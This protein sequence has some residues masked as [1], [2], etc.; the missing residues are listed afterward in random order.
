[1]RQRGFTLLEVLIAA[2]ILAIVTS[3][4]YA[5][6][7]N[8]TNSTDVVRTAMKELRARQFL[9]RVFLQNFTTIVTDPYLEDERF[10]F[11]AE[12]SEGGGGP[13]DKVFFCSTAPLL[14]GASFPGDI[15]QVSLEVDDPES[16]MT[17]ELG[18]DDDRR[19]RERRLVA[20]EIPL[21]GARVE[22]ADG[23][24]GEVTADASFE[25]TPWDFPVR[26]MDLQY[27]DGKEWV[28]DWDSIEMKRL[29]WAVYIRLNYAKS[30]SQLEAESYESFDTKDDPDFEMVI[31]IPSGLSVTE[32]MLLLPELMEEESM[33][34]TEGGAFVD[35][36]GD[37]TAVREKPQSGGVTVPRDSGASVSRG[38]GASDQ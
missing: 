16:D 21:L 26:S 35:T 3:I 25:P 17:L 18:E 34:G 37:G 32:D 36:D 7:A 19:Q 31:P 15:K 24:T 11:K 1:M 14:F 12:N 33:A 38:L 6:F 28:D 29:P 5:S 2:A 27:F 8:V 20:T 13:A 22:E 10:L 30:E 4:V 9:T 23:L